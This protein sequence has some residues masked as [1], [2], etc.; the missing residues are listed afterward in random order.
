MLYGASVGKSFEHFYNQKLWRSS[1]FQ[2]D[3]IARVPRIVGDI[4]NEET[5]PGKNGY[6]NWVDEKANY[7]CIEDV[8]K[9][10]QDAIPRGIKIIKLNRLVGPEAT[11]EMK[12]D[13]KVQGHI[14][15]GR[16]DFVIHRV[17]PHNDRVILD[18][19]GSKFRDRYTDKRQLRWYAM[20]YKDRYKV[21]PDK[22]GFLFWRSEPETSIDWYE[23]TEADTQALRSAIFE[24]V[25]TIENGVR[26]LPIAPKPAREEVVSFFP[27]QPSCDCKW[28]NYLSSCEDGMRYEK[29]RG[30]IPD[31]D[32]SEDA[33]GIGVESVV[34]RS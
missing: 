20:L 28:C 33:E 3:M 13:S 10:V 26:H 8:I 6:I 31:P 24:A 2:E 18:G 23:V 22:V 12:L 25:E 19:K 16:A 5:A 9:D 11:S 27:A 4:I 7:H 30:K 21:L 14:F 17:P 15:G 29:N 1:T 34:T 32:S